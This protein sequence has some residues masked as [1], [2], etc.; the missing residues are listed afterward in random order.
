[1]LRRTGLAADFEKW[2]KEG[3]GCGRH[4]SYRPWLR[5]QDSSSKAV[6]TRAYSVRF[7][8]F[9]HFLSHGEYLTFLQ[10]E[11]N[12]RTLE[13]YEQ[14]PL[15]PS[16]TQAI[17]EEFGFRHP[18]VKQ[19]DI[20]MT[21]DFLVT[22][23]RPNDH[24]EK[25]AIQ[26]KH[27]QADLS[28]RALEKIAIEK[29]YWRRKGVEFVLSLSSEFNFVFCRNLQTLFPFRSRKISVE[30]LKRSAVEF[31]SFKEDIFSL[32][33]MVSPEA[34]PCIKLLVA[35]QLLAYPLKE[36]SIYEAQW[37]DLK[38]VGHAA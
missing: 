4:E 25:Y 12:P 7:G 29:E 23:Q 34:L 1:M 6:K 18:R 27:S 15:D 9:F 20:V 35:N 24:R 22:L 17:A 31:K 19:E 10:Y 32:N 21:T 37:S 26:I 16:I 14:Y 3:R 38:G 2:Q 8:R 5:T 36:K 11:W 13:I 30:Q 33:E 28:D